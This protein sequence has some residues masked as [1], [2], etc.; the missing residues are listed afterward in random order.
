MWWHWFTM[1]SMTKPAAIA[2][3]PRIQVTLPPEV[4]AV[5]DQVSQLTGQGK[6]TIVSE[7]M[8]EALPMLRT[9]V[10]AIEVVKS[11]PR[12]AQ[13]MMN[14]V[15]AEAVLKLSQHQLEFDDLLAAQPRTKRQRRKK[16]SD[17]PA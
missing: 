8:V 9:M 12:D 1:P 6:G 10:T 17:G 5:L 16:G 4:M 2:R 13:A 3:S 15:S 11:A 14:R 7:M